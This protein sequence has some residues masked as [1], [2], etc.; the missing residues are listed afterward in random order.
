MGLIGY[1][2]KVQTDETRAARLSWRT[3]LAGAGEVPITE[4]INSF[5][6]EMWRFDLGIELC[7]E[8]VVDETH[9]PGLS[10]SGRDG[11]SCRLDAVAGVR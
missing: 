8:G 7:V 6:V 11:A 10:E 5:W 9:G 1:S 3:D 2:F 4:P